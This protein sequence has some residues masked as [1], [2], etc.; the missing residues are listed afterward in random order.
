MPRN[1][2]LYLHLSRFSYCVCIQQL[3]PPSY[4]PVWAYLSEGGIRLNRNIGGLGAGRAGGELEHF[5]RSQRYSWRGREQ[6]R[7]PGQGSVSLE[8]ECDPPAE[9]GQ[10]MSAFLECSGG[11][12]SKGEGTG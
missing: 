7:K 8:A 2:Y 4:F 5:A 3:N 12:I 6:Q 10:Q 1:F 9:C 11:C